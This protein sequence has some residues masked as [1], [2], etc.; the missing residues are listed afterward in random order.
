MRTKRKK[1]TARPTI[2]QGHRDQSRTARPAE[3]TIRTMTMRRG[4]RKMKRRM[5]GIGGRRS[6]GMIRMRIATESGPSRY[7]GTRCNRACSEGVG[8]LPWSPSG[9]VMYFV[10]VQS[11]FVHESIYDCTS[12]LLACCDSDLGVACLPLSRPC[13]WPIPGGARTE[14]NQH[15][16][17]KLTDD[18]GRKCQHALEYR[19]TRVHRSIY[20]DNLWSLHSALDIAFPIRTSYKSERAQVSVTACYQ[21]SPKF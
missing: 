10:F 5:C 6:G 16:L 9:G 20:S 11:S 1:R 19:S 8:G 13:A 17:R 4:R 18:A 2:E 12:A 7:N 21:S 3:I 14:A 15:S